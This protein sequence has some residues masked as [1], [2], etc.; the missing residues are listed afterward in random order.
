MGFMRIL[1][2]CVL[3]L[4]GTSWVLAAHAA[5]PETV[6]NG[7]ETDALGREKNMETYLQRVDAAM[8]DVARAEDLRAELRGWQAATVGLIAGET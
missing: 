6:R 8:R 7:P 3:Y 1:I 5:S 4:L 2:R